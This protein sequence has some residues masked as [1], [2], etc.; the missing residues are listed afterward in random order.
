MFPITW[1]SLNSNYLA[2]FVL[3]FFPLFLVCVFVSLKKKKKK[4]SDFFNKY[5]NKFSFFFSGLEKYYH[6]FEPN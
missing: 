4:I 6:Y 3:E 2:S 5:T 1:A